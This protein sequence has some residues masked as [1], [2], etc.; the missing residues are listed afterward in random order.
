MRIHLDYHR[1]KLEADIPDRNLAQV[2]GLKT[3]PGPA[4][5]GGAC[6][7]ALA[8]PSGSPPLAEIARGRA[9]A[10]VV[11]SDITRPVPNAVILPPLLRE[12]ETAGVAR[13]SIIVL[14]ATGLHRPNEGDE[15]REMVGDFVFE[16]YRIENHHAR[17]GAHHDLGRTSQGVPVQV[18]TRF[19]EADV[20]V[21]TGLVE[22]HFMA[23]FSGGRKAVCP[24]ISSAE[25]ILAFHS[26]P[27]IEHERSRTG[28]LEG[29]PIHA[30]AR[31]VARRAGVHFCL[32][33][34][35]NDKREP[36]GFFAGDLDAAFEQ[37]VARVREVSFA[38]I[39]GPAD[40]V[41][42]S[43]GGYP[44]DLTWY[45]SIKGI[46]AA[47]PAVK[48]GGTIILASGIREGLGGEEFTRMCLE[49]HDIEAFMRGIRESGRV[50]IDQW[51]LEELGMALRKA[52]VMLF[53][54]GLDMATQ[55][56][57]N[58]EPVP[59]V[60]HGVAAC[61]ERY[62]PDASVIVIPKGPYVNP[63][64]PANPKL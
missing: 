17:L 24:G 58:V 40:I 27:L 2:L 3:T 55:R 46:V 51:E 23:G 16:N 32:N 4:D 36:V 33:V 21:V 43:G 49:T 15:L 26:P 53:T 48:P 11:I 38:P 54:D 57:L 52:R 10:C 41:V 47:L 7:Q 6:R 13:E 25:A 45:Q 12:L 61:L 35:I 56:E 19:I 44:L 28:L 60:E 29:N 5:P 34:V 37:A 14:V 39:P 50:V 22:P 30:A 9:S 18:N 59:S 31:E 1:E 63:E 42:T 20:R 62:G 64:P 8:N